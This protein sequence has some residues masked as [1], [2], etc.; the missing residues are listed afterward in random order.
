MEDAQIPQFIRRRRV[1]EITGLSKSEI[2]RRASAG[3]F[4]KAVSVSD[5]DDNGRGHRWVLSEVLAWQNERLQLRQR[6]ASRQ[7]ARA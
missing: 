5:D 3:T 6:S 2:Y 1:E 4:P 7:E